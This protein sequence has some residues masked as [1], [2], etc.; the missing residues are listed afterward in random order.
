LDRRR[1][2]L[3][4]RDLRY[5]AGGRCFPRADEQSM[6]K[7]SIC[8]LLAG[9]LVC[10]VGRAKACS[11]DNRVERNYLFADQGSMYDRNP[12]PSATQPVTLTLRTCRG[13]ISSAS[14]E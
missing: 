13:D 3:R 5:A 14:I 9:A 10:G 7:I 1:R 4:W 2:P 8:I 11:R 6:N 12:E